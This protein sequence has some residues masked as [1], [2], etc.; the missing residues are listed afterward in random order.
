LR[1]SCPWQQIAEK[2]SD[3]RGVC[4]S[5]EEIEEQEM[6][7]SQHPQDVHHDKHRKSQS[8]PVGAKDIKICFDVLS[9]WPASCFGVHVSLP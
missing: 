2:S 8:V 3:F 4:K 7:L 6:G 1:T 5:Q 9:C